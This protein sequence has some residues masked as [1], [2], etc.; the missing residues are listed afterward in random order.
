VRALSVRAGS[1]FVLVAWRAPVEADFDHVRVLRAAMRG[2]AG[3][4]LV[5]QGRG[6]R[7]KDTKV[8]NGSRYRYVVVSYDRAGNASAGARVLAAPSALLRPQ[9]GAS[10]NAPP[11]LAWATVPGASYY[12]LQVYRGPIKVLSAWPRKN[13]FSLRR[14]WKYRGRSWRLTATVYRWYVWPGF[15]PLRAERYGKLLGE[16]RFKVIS[17]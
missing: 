7:Y 2:P 14:S 12:N 6:L 13:G 15:G 4:V 5:Y 10:I 16:H 11:I 9:D 8:K 1:G 17:P 3:F